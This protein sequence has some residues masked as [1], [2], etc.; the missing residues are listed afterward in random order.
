[1]I[2]DDLY[3]AFYN[4]KWDAYL[5][6]VVYPESNKHRYEWDELTTEPYYSVVP[7]SDSKTETEISQTNVYC[8]EEALYEA[9]EYINEGYPDFFAKQLDDIVLVA[10]D[11]DEP[12]FTPLPNLRI[13]TGKQH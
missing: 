1:M 4:I 13:V 5:N 11:Y 7:V 2:D 3:Y 10:I 6:E 8:W 12:D 9:T